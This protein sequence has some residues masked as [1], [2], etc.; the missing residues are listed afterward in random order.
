MEATSFLSSFKKKLLLWQRKTIT[1][2]FIYHIRSGK[3]RSL[4]EVICWAGL[5][6]FEPHSLCVILTMG[7]A[8]CSMHRRIRAWLFSL[9]WSFPSPSRSTRAGKTANKKKE[10]KTK[11]AGG[12]YESQ[13]TTSAQSAPM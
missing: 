13:S 2:F 1:V 8:V 4:I 6:E 10:N 7:D 3:S 5:E 11:K 9:T 12:E